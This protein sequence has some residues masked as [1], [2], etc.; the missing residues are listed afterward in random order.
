MDPSRTQME[1]LLPFPLVV[2]D[3]AVAPHLKDDDITFC[4]LCDFEVTHITSHVLIC[5]YQDDRI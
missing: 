2:M 3:D 4:A 1:P 5:N